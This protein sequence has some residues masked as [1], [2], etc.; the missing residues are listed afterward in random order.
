MKPHIAGSN[1]SDNTDR[2]VNM[3]KV[4]A[5]NF[6]VGRKLTG[7]LPEEIGEASLSSSDNAEFA[8]S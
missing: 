2:T 6:R 5:A 4:V 8:S 3:G 7:L 1:K